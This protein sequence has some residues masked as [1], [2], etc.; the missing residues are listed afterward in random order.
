M[1]ELVTVAEVVLLL[2][3]PAG[4][5]SHPDEPERQKHVT[6]IEE[7]ARKVVPERLPG[8]KVVRVESRTG[9]ELVAIVLG[10]VASGASA[11]LIIAAVKDYPNLRAGAKAIAEDV[12]T[13]YNNAKPK[14][15]A[16]PFHVSCVAVKPPAGD[17]SYGEEMRRWLVDE[18]LKDEQ[19]RERVIHWMRNRQP[20]IQGDPS[21]WALDD[22]TDAAL[23]GELARH[24]RDRK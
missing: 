17:R 19:V 11:S 21:F 12:C 16:T 8:M 6:Q 10:I 4:A 14:G 20:P 9:C 23:V 1:P 22:R 24:L 5:L 15:R 3:H 18:V 13:L 2:N 7:I